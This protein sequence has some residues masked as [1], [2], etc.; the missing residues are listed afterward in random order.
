VSVAAGTCY[1]AVAEKRPWYI[2]PSRGRC[3]SNGS[4][5]YSMYTSANVSNI[6][7]AWSLRS[8]LDTTSLNFFT[9]FNGDLFQYAHQHALNSSFIINACRFVLWSIFQA[10]K[11]VNGLPRIYTSTM[12]WKSIYVC[13]W[14]RPVT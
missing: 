6:S 2:R 3:I 7:F 11:I 10:K 12:C 9:V 14:L 5:R 13:D 4:T 8:A 1:R